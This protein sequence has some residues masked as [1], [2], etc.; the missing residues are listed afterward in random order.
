MKKILVRNLFRHFKSRLSIGKQLEEFK[1]KPA[2]HWE[3]KGEK[4]AMT[5]FKYVCANV[6]AYRKFL[7][8][9]SINFNKIKSFAD[10]KS[11]P[12][13]TKP[14]YL[15]KYDYIKLFPEK[16]LFSAT[17][18]SATSGST[19]EPFFF[20]REEEHDYQ[21]ENASEIFLRNQ[22]SL[23][24][25]RTLGIVGF[26]LGIWIGGI[27]T[28]KNFNKIAQKG[29]DFTLIPVGPNKDLYLKAFKKF[30]PYYDQIILM[31]YPPFMKDLLDAGAEEGINWKDYDLRILTA[32]EGY[33]ENFR[34]YL[35]EKSGVKNVVND[36][37]NIYG[38]VE[39]GTIA[40]ETS[41]SNMIRKIAVENKVVF[42]EL[43]PKATNVPTLAQYYPQTVYFEE[44]DG[45]LVA[46]SYGSS[47]PLVRYEFSDLGGVITFDEMMAKLK[48]C[49][50]DVLKE[51][52]KWK[53]NH[54]IL[55]LP[56]VY[57]YARSDFAV[58]FRGANIYPDEIR[59]IL[60]SK[61]F[62]DTLTGK[63]TMIRKETS[64]L[65][66][67]L[68]INVELKKDVTISENLQRKICDVIMSELKKTNSEYAYLLSLEPSKVKPSVVLYNYNDLKYFGSTAK[69]EWVKNNS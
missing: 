61:E 1:S 14:N 69:Q 13:T 11:L 23:D 54:K 30:A 21:Y 36:I 58:V 49:G 12:L 67:T 48:K 20:P 19:G 22:F 35:A 40:H 18:I 46:T 41:F 4:N 60:D 9:H 44:V 38:T 2:S 66:Q 47:I 53:I 65:N 3:K 50:V 34:N 68:E 10:F 33:S 6:P 24:K 5:L 15:R 42:K 57:M 27:F 56:F 29:Y 45:K 28:Y 39:Q 32:A 52:K 51:A 25:K 7:R 43:F 63:F 37:V 17:T 31:G 8:E 64:D 16:M 59:N 62:S 55:R 26:G